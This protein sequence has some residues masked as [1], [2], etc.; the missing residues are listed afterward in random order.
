M[1]YQ[2]K[3]MIKNAT[4]WVTF[5]N[6]TIEEDIFKEVVWRALV[7]IQRANP[8]FHFEVYSEGKKFEL[9]GGYL[10]KNITLVAHLWGD[11]VSTPSFHIYWDP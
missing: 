8:D 11:Y 9:W 10:E 4:G 5:L 7:L 1:K 2:V 6:L 3:L